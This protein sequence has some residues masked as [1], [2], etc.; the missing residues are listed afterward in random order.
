VKWTV[1]A[2][3]T[4]Y[5]CPWFR[6]EQ[7]DVTLPDGQTFPHHVIR[8]PAPVVAVLAVDQHDR[9]LLLHRHRF[10]TNRE[11]WELPAGAA[12]PGEDPAAAAA[13]ELA[14]ETGVACGQLELL[15]RADLSNGLTDQHVL[16]YHGRATTTGGVITSPEESDAQ[17]WLTPTELDQLLTHDE[18]HDALTQVALLHHRRAAH[19][20]RPAV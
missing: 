7:T 3:R 16:I 17:R 12:D 8:T 14:E 10:I 18:V 1:G 19:P 13:R 2:S 5:D 20:D 9:V 11:G 4:L 15:A 6:L